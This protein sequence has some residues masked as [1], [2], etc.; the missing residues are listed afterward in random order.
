MYQIDNDKLNYQPELRLADRIFKIDN[1]LSVFRRISARLGE[2]GGDEFEIIVGE[3][4][5]GAALEEILGMDL[6]YGIMQDLIIIVLAAI[7]DLPVEEAR[8]RFRGAG[9]E[10][11]SGLL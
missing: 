10:S 5:G 1:R 3:A 8:R 7:Q 9:G 2:G 6:P 11:G 4:L